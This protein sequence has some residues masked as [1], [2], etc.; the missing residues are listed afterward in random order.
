MATKTFEELKQ[1]AIQIRDEKTNKQNTATRIGT[2]MLG[3]LDKLEQDYYD[4]TATDEKLIELEKELGKLNYLSVVE[5]KYINQNGIETEGINFAC[6]DYIKYYYGDIYAYNIY[7]KLNAVSA[8][9]FY[10]ENKDFISSITSTLSGGEIINGIIEK[11]K[12]PTNTKYVRFSQNYNIDN[13]KELYVKFVTPL[14]DENYQEQ[15]DNI[16]NKI[17]EINNT[18]DNE[19]D[20]AKQ[21]NTV[22]NFKN[23]ELSFTEG[24]G[25]NNGNETTSVSAASCTDYIDIE[26]YKNICTL[27]IIAQFGLDSCAFY[28]EN[29]ALISY[30]KSAD[31]YKEVVIPQKAK[32][33]R[34]CTNKSNIEKAKLFVKE[35]IIYGTNQIKNNKKRI[36]SIPTKKVYYFDKGLLSESASNLSSSFGFIIPNKRITGVKIYVDEDKEVS[37]NIFTLNKDLNIYLNNSYTIQAKQGINEYQLDIDLTD[38]E[39]DIYY[40]P[41]SGFVYS[42]DSSGLTGKTMYNITNLKLIQLGQHNI[43]HTLIQMLIWYFL[44]II[45]MQIWLK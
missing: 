16:N 21:E 20:S 45:F 27:Y 31:I 24:L 7:G 43:K 29:K 19:N 37:F 2:Q 6:S 22:I 36:D 39:G 28:D 5:N 10:D 30:E 9:A 35:D 8:I 13:D 32:Y 14:S 34:L 18:L 12:I 11:S 25:L 23:Y 40:S 4:K 38:V 15:I 33:I 44:T 42:R 17:E 3:H 26:E 41:I 1:L